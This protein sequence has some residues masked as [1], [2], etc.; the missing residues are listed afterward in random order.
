VP[1]K[2]VVSAAPARLLDILGNI[3]RGNAWGA[4][5]SVLDDF[6]EERAMTDDELCAAALA[7]DPD[8]IVSDDAVCLWELTGYGAQPLPEWYMPAPMGGS[9]WGWRRH[10]ARFNIALIIASFLAINAYGLCNTYGQLHF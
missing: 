7:A 8:T 6:S 4:P 5:V 2:P 1:R 10:F 3:R 9:L